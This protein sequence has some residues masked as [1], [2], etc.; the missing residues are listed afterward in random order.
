MVV[1]GVVTGAG[2]LP[3]A[4]PQAVKASSAGQM[5]EEVSLDME[6]FLA[7]NQSAPQIEEN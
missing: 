4:P 7:G 1:G 3:P 5:D 2:V 6:G